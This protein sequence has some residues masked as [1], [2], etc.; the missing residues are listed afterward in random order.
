MKNTKSKQSFPNTDVVKLFASFNRGIFIPLVEPNNT[1]EI[2]HQRLKELGARIG[3]GSVESLMNGS[4]DV[5]KDFKVV[6]VNDHKTQINVSEQ[7]VV[8][9]TVET[10]PNKVI[11]TTG[12]RG[13]VRSLGYPPQKR[14]VPLKRGTI[15]ASLMEMV[16]DGA[17]IKEMLEFT[18]NTTMGG[19]NNLIGHIIKSKGYGVSYD[20]KSEKYTLV[21]PKGITELIYD[22]FE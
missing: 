16:K 15:Y 12:R 20:P 3:K 7:P 13:K 10:K 5:I 11:K 1:P 9:E 17:T 14:L 21:F 6:S 8:S 2:V 19:V 22:D 18:G 4:A